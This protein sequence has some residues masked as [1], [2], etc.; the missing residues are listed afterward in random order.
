MVVEP[1]CMAQKDLMKVVAALNG[2]GC[3]PYLG[4]SAQK[5]SKE[6]C[7]NRDDYQELN[8]GESTTHD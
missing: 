7:D 3:G 5:Q 4:H 2:I 6:D 1:E 8:Q